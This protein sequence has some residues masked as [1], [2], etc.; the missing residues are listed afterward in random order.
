M[1][2]PHVPKSMVVIGA[3]AIGV[4]FAYFYSSFGTKVTLVEML[5]HLLPIEDEEMSKEL[6]RAFTKKR[7]AWRTSTKVASV[8]RGEKS[9]RAILAGPKG[10][11]K[12]EADVALVAIG[13]KGNVEDIGLEEARVHHE[14]GS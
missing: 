14:R 12:V 5:P 8:E 10:E 13:V 4:E 1:L 9:I 3:G 6:E 2:L 11:E 7:I